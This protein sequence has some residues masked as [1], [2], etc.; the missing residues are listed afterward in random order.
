MT[1]TLR[2]WW[3]GLSTRERWLVGIAGTLTALVLLWFAVIMPLVNGLAAARERHTAAVERHA[4]VAARA[5]MAEQQAGRG[6]AVT[7]VSGRVDIIISQSAAEQGFILSRNDAVGESS[8]SIAI[9]NARAA[10]VFTWLGLLEAQQLIAS[11][12]TIRPNADGTVA[13][14]A[15]ITRSQ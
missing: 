3:T 13:V 12:L 10:A 7:R 11:E 9:G 5:R 4:G 6:T 2:N 14:T 1:Q 15:T 8:A